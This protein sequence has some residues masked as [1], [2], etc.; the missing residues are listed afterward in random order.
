MHQLMFRDG[1]WDRDIWRS[2]TDGNEYGVEGRF[3]PSDVVIDIGAHI[4]AFSYLVLDHGAGRVISVE[5]DPENAYYLRHNVHMACGA[6]DRCVIVTAAAGAEW[7][8]AEFTAQPVNTGGGSLWPADGDRRFPVA[9]V[10]FDRLVDLAGAVR[11]LKLDC[12]GAEWDILHASRR[13]DRVTEIVGE[14]HVPA[15]GRGSGGEEELK[16]LLRRAGFEVATRP[17]ADRM[18]LFTARRS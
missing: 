2:V 5:P 9:V 1:T 6:T 17:T 12:E 18:G 16:D 14:Y 4:G 8:V 3:E 13:L 11:L 15:G 7:G 10:P